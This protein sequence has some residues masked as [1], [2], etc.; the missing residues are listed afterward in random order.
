MPSTGTPS[1]PHVTA[2]QDKKPPTGTT[3]GQTDARAI[4]QKILRSFGLGELN[5]WAWKLITQGA[6]VDQITAEL[7]QQ[8]LFKLKFPGIIMRQELGLPPISMA[9]YVA[10]EDQ[11]HQLTTQSGLPASV[12]TTEFMGKLIGNDVSASEFSDRIVKGFA[13]VA[14]APA[15]VQQTFA[16]WFGAKGP[17]QLA[18]YFLNPKTGADVLEH[19]AMMA[20]VQGAGVNAG[21]NIGRNRASQLAA[22]GDTYSQVAGALTKLTTTAGLYQANQQEGAQNRPIRGVTGQAANLTE[23]N[24]GV[25]ATLGL[26]AAAEQE[27]EQRALERQNA[28]R[29]GG[30]A[31]QQGQQG[32]TGLGAAKA[33]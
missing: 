7:Y 11:Y 4:I 3:P 21:V 15:S 25:D 2:P 18:A 20:Q 8:P 27:V 26:S 19:E 24:Q 9:S 22:M 12:L 10:L 1:G 29:G 23:S 32:Y 5:N 28:F 6:G 17:A 14:Q 30:G 31:A 16:S 33:F 13:T